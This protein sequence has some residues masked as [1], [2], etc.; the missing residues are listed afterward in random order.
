MRRRR[1]F[2]P[3]FD[4]LMKRDVPSG[5]AVPI[6]VPVTIGTSPTVSPIDTQMPDPIGGFPGQVIAPV[7]TDFQGSHQFTVYD[8]P[9]PTLA[10]PD[11]LLN[12]PGPQG[13]DQTALIPN[14][15]P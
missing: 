7:P 3:N 8:V 9:T 1:S 6:I 10:S 13:G 14:D 12:P 2:T 11:Q 5:M 4:K 15:T